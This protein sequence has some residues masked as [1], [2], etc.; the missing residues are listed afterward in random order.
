MV[1]MSSKLIFDERI[2]SMEFLSKCS[3]DVIKKAAQALY[4]G[5]LVAFPT[6][7]V[8]GLGAD[9]TNSEAVARIYSVKGRPADH[10]LIVHIASMQEMDQWSSDIP[11]YAIKLARAYWPGPMTLILKRSDLAKDFITGG[12]DTVG[13]RVPNHP[14]A[15]AL[16]EEFQKAGGHGVAAPSA[17]R[18]GAV[19][20][21]TAEAVQDELTPYLG[22]EDL[23]LDGGNSQV[24]VESTIIDCTGE[25]PRVLRLGAIT[26]EQ[27]ELLV[28]QI[29]V[30]ERKNEIRVS[31]SLESHYSPRAK[32]ILDSI[33]KPGQGFIAMADVETPHGAIRLASPVNAEEYAKQLYSALRIGDGQN[34]PAIVAITPSG[35]GLAEAIRDRLLRAAN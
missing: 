25:A 23:I 12:Q 7:T 8:Y 14:I 13:L 15:L 22:D 29:A 26:S 28:G 4:D 33:P 17:N 30:S 20:P 9:A 10:P 34:L 21:T 11:E 18:F 2:M 16:L 32:V 19:S 1:W 35:L 5:H 24:G 6:E 3:T 31:G 27:I